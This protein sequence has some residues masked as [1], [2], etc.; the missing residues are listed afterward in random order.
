M[1]ILKSEKWEVCFVTKILQ[2]KSTKKLNL[3][4][5]AELINKYLRDA[6]TVNRQGTVTI[7]CLDLIIKFIE[8]LCNPV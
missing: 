5:I 8:G 3:S 6:F 2:P 1:G 4:K 7:D